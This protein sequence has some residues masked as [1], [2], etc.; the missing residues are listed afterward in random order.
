MLVSTLLLAPYFCVANT[1]SETCFYVLTKDEVVRVS[2]TGMKQT[3]IGSRGE[4]DSIEILDNKLYVSDKRRGGNILVYDFEGSLLKTIP[5]PSEASKYLEFTILPDE[6]IALLDNV[7]DKVYFI[8]SSGSL[9]ATVNILDKPDSHLQNLD[10]I[11]VGNYLILSEDGDNHVL[12]INLDTY[13]KSVFKDLSNLTHWLGA[14]TYSNGRYYICGPRTIYSFLEGGA[15]NKIAEIPES[16]IIGIVIVDN[17]AYVGVN[18]AGKLYRVDLTSGDASVFVTDLNY[19]HDLEV[20]SAPLPRAVIPWSLSTVLWMLGAVLA[21][22]GIGFAPRAGKTARMA[23]RILVAAIIF[24]LSFT[25]YYPIAQ[26]PANV[27]DPLRDLFYLELATVLLVTFLFS[28]LEK[29]LGWPF[30]FGN[31]LTWGLVFGYNFFFGYPYWLIV[32]YL[33]VEGVF[34]GFLYV[35][36]GAVGQRFIGW[37]GNRKISSQL[38]ARALTNV[39]VASGVSTHSVLAKKVRCRKCGHA[40]PDTDLYCVYCGVRNRRSFL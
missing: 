2:L 24:E 31:S 5:T 22:G 16:N 32:L 21:V 3:I 15:V 27:S 25:M 36:L 39:P 13:Q 14:I 19:P 26:L 35:F 34:F 29:G 38:K 37:V 11:V 4:T 23:R 20:A 28:A 33:I 6:R 8:N 9:L 1:Q 10:G 7:Y 30:I 17:Y 18:F 12:K 40:I